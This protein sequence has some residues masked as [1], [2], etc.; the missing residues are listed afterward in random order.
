MTTTSTSNRPLLLP[1]WKMVEGTTTKTTVSASFVSCDTTRLR[2]SKRAR[3]ESSSLH[4]ATTTTTTSPE[5]MTSPNEP[6][7]SSTTA[8]ASTALT[9]LT[10]RHNKRRRCDDGPSTA[11]DVFPTTSQA[12]RS[13]LI[14]SIRINKKNVIV[15]STEDPSEK[16]PLTTCSITKTGINAFEEYVE[17]LKT[18]LKP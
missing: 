7:L 12:L 2:V 1:G 3:N 16:K 5:L 11:G 9:A 10:T 17:T 18:Y 6:S 13:F 14:H 8:P 15:P 4:S